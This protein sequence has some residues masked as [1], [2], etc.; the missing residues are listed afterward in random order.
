ME[1]LLKK[2]FAKHY[3]TFYLYDDEEYKQAVKLFK[4]NLL[5][6]Y[7]PEQ[8]TYTDENTLIALKKN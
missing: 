2:V 4:Q 5:K 3:S 1:E 7:D 6:Y 8:I